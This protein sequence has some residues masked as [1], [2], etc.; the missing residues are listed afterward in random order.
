MP[1]SEILQDSLA[2]IANGGQ[3]QAL[4]LK[5]LLCVLQLHELRFAEGS[6]VSRTEEQKD[7]ALA[8]LE[9]LVRLLM[10]KLIGQNK[11][12]PLLPNFQP[13]RGCNAVIRGRIF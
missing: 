13:N 2:I 9:R 11:C 7:G 1:I 6:P 12:R 4:R 10:T 5:S 3:L 8:S